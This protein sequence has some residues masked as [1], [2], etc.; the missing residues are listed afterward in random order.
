MPFAVG[1]L[2][3]DGSDLPLRLEGEAAAAGTTRVL[4]IRESEQAFRFVD[5]PSRP[6]P[7]LLRGFSAPVKVHYEYGDEA[8]TFLMAHDA[9]GFNRWDAAQTLAQKV[10]LARVGD[11]EAAVPAGFVEAIRHAL[12][13]PGADGALL[14][15]MLTLPSEPYL[16]DQMPEVDVDGI[17]RAREGVKTALAEALRD[18]FLRAYRAAQET[19][20]H[21]LEPASIARRSLKNVALGYLMQLGDAEAVGLALEQYGAAHNMTDALAALALLADGDAPARDGVIADFRA[22]WQHDPLV[23]DKWFGVQAMARRP[24][25]L[26]RVEQLMRDPAFSIRN[27]NKVRALIGTF[28]AANPVRFHAADGAGYAFL[29]D[30]VLE[31]DPLNPQVAARLLRGMARWRRYDAARQALMRSQLERVRRPRACRRTST[32]SHPGASRHEPAE[33]DRQPLP[34]QHG[35]AVA[36]KALLLVAHGSRRE[37]SNQ[38]IRDLT[39][40]L[41]AAPGIASATSATPSSRSPSRRS[42][43]AYNSASTRARPRSWCCRTSCRLAGTSP[44]TSPTTSPS[45]RP[46]TRTSGCASRPTSARPTRSWTSS[47]ALRL[48]RAAGCRSGCVGL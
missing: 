48:R 7:S 1:L 24:D 22:R 11:P 44:R 32:R 10:I 27:P 41:A 35:G 3:P 8:L 29:V 38:E 15:E 30:R 31:L 36:V 39:A 19:G 5:V 4:D 34:I 42:P 37:S 9:D 13:E 20:P 25:T 21:D 28:C 43:T 46:S 45:N 47:S 16:G 2:G 26:A 17:H 33:T 18:D 14:A 6:V 23:M 40:R 12:R